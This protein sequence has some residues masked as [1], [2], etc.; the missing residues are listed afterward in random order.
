MLI[1]TLQFAHDPK[2]GMLRLWAYP[3]T[4]VCFAI[5]GEGSSFNLAEWNCAAADPLV[6]QRV[7]LARG[8]ER[9]F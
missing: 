2:M 6:C 5:F 1:A 3:A 7:P 8:Q 4:R 9:T